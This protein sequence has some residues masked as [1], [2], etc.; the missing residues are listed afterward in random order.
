MSR[1][2]IKA[3][4]ENIRLHESGTLQDLLERSGGGGELGGTSKKAMKKLRKEE[5]EKRKRDKTVARLE[6][7]QEEREAKQERKERKKRDLE[8]SLAPKSGQTSTAASTAGDDED[9]NLG[10]VIDVVGA[11][12]AGASADPVARRL[13]PEASAADDLADEEESRYSIPSTS[14]TS[15]SAAATYKR[16]ALAKAK[17]LEPIFV[18]GAASDSS[19]D[20]DEEHDDGD[21]MMGGGTG[22]LLVGSVSTAKSK[23]PSPKKR[24]VLAR[25]ASGSSSSDSEEEYVRAM[26]Q[27]L[28]KKG[29]AGGAEDEARKQ[30]KAAFWASKGKLEAEG[31]WDS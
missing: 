9:A 30:A 1:A 6:M 14:S 16:D 13:F 27:P 17:A 23:E 28:E 20:D 11:P 7:R 25:S 22:D 15:T 2:G 21:V 3:R 4:G 10:F 26:L 8:A 5:R 24:K 31:E 12:P 18:N 19:S 29:S